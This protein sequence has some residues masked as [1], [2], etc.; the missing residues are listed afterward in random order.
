MEN[1]CIYEFFNNASI[2]ALLSVVVGILLGRH[3]YREQKK[4][5]RE[6]VA[7]NKIVEALILLEE[8]CKS[9][10]QTIDRLS[11]TYKT[12]IP[13]EIVARQKF[14][15]GSFVLEISIASNIL[16]NKIP[17]DVSKIESI[18]SL[19]YDNEL[20]KNI[21]K[22]IFEELKKW[23]DYVQIYIT[24]HGSK[25]FDLVTRVSEI[26]ELSLV[27]LNTAIKKFILELK[28]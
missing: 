2:A 16:M 3:I 10:N 4:V 1:T 21:S 23:H 18:I 7:E 20:L 8:H 9:V 22:D 25:K 6:I 26:P 24:G 15:D 12:I 5:D 19:Y 11:N 14:I 27:P 28:K 17:E 13:D